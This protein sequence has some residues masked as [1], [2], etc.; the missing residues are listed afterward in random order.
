VRR[1][2]QF[3]N[4]KERDYLEDLGEDG[5]ITLKFTFLKEV[6]RTWIR[7]TGRF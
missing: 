5:R 6:G 7:I 2:L 3:E 1:W 4:L